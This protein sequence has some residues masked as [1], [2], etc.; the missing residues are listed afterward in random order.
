MLR[1]QSSRRIA[2]GD[3]ERG[4]EADP[5]THPHPDAPIAVAVSIE[6]ATTRPI[7]TLA[8]ATRVTV[9]SASD[10]QKP[11]GGWRRRGQARPPGRRV[12]DFAS[13]P[14][15]VC[16]RRWALVAIELG[17]DTST[18]TGE[19]VANVMMFV[20]QWEHRVIDEPVG[21]DASG[22]VRRKAH[23]QGVRSAGGNRSATRGPA[24]NDHACPHR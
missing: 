13:I 10:S 20:A 6:S 9:A 22:Q 24:R 7:P 19:L 8:A 21:S 15:L 4:F 11:G 2:R 1:D 18:S 5:D 23:G 17:A 12:A 3:D 16:A 14:E